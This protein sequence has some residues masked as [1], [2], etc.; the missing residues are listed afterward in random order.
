M[1]KNI[2]QKLVPKPL[3]F[4]GVYFGQWNNRG[5]KKDV[6]FVIKRLNSWIRIKSRLSDNRILK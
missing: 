5:N 4:R 2:V 1:K 3:N 6:N